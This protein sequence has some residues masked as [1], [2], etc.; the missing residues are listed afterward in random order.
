MSREE[1]G[2]YAH[3]LLSYNMSLNVRVEGCCSVQTITKQ[4]RMASC[5]ANRLGCAPRCALQ[6][7]PRPIHNTEDCGHRCGYARIIQRFRRK[8]LP[9]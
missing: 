1:T 8:T 7:Q 5:K 4:S 3:R 6:Q 9:N 2:R